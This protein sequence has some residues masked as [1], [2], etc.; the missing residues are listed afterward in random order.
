MYFILRLNVLN[1]FLWSKIRAF[2]IVGELHPKADFDYLNFRHHH[3][4]PR[5]RAILLSPLFGPSGMQ[6]TKPNL[7]FE[8]AIEITLTAQDKELFL[9]DEAT[10]E[11]LLNDMREWDKLHARGK[12]RKVAGRVKRFVCGMEQ[13]LSVI[14]M[15]VQYNVQPAALI[16]GGC[17]LLLVVSTL[18]Q[19]I[20]PRW[21]SLIT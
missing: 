2:R 1:V 7:A 16:W 15:I 3:L 8:R 4:V 20:F 13:Y 14:D 12:L 5:S 21:C 9:K 19:T 6:S 10:P 18:N 11:R 17:R